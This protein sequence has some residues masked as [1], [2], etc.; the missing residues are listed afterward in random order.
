MT[1][2][3]ISPSTEITCGYFSPF[4]G[5]L[6]FA[7]RR[8]KLKSQWKFDCKCDACLKYVS[9]QDVSM[10]VLRELNGKIAGILALQLSGKTYDSKRW[11]I[12]LKLTQEQE[13]HIEET[14]NSDVR[15]LWHIRFNMLI[16]TAQMGD[17]TKTMAMVQKYNAEFR[18][19][20]FEWSED[21]LFALSYFAKRFKSKLVSVPK[22]KAI[23]EQSERFG[24]FFLL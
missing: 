2:K 21:R 17:D 16:A 4:D 12:I 5:D 20:H 10:N 23:F 6:S 14:F 9:Q 1:L 18:D 15:A 3:D 8:K 11:G 7:E 22:R 19:I 13:S 24:H